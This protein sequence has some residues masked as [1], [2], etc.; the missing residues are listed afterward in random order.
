M[1]KTE[2]IK[3]TE[4]ELKSLVK[5]VVVREFFERSPYPEDREFDSDSEPYEVDSDQGLDESTDMDRYED[6]VFLQ[7]DSADEAIEILDNQGE[8]AAMDYLI[9]WHEPG[10]HMGSS[11]LS[12]GSSDSTYERDGYIMSYNIP[13]NYI[14]LQYE[15]SGMNESK[16]QDKKK[17][18]Q[19]KFDKVMGEFGDGTLKTPSGDVVTDRKQA[20]AIAYSESGLD[21]QTTEVLKEAFRLSRNA[22]ELKQIN[23]QQ[24]E[25]AFNKGYVLYMYL[26]LNGNASLST[27]TNLYFLTKNYFD[28]STPVRI[29]PKNVEPSQV[30]FKAI[31]DAYSRRASESGSDFRIYTLFDVNPYEIN[32]NPDDKITEASDFYGIRNQ[33]AYPK[34]GNIGGPHKQPI[35]DKDFNPKI[36]VEKSKI[37]MFDIEWL[38]KQ[39]ERLFGMNNY[40]DTKRTFD[41]ERNLNSL[42]AIINSFKQQRGSNAPN[43]IEWVVRQFKYGLNN[44]PKEFSIHFGI[45]PDSDK[46]I[47]S[48]LDHGTDSFIGNYEKFKELISKGRPEG[49]LTHESK[50]KL[51]NIVENVVRKVMLEKQDNFKV[52]LG[53]ITSQKGNEWRVKGDSNE[54]F[55]VVRPMDGLLLQMPPEVNEIGANKYGY[56]QVKNTIENLINQKEGGLTESTDLKHYTLKVKHDNGKVNLKT[57]ASSEKEAKE[58]IMKAEGCPESAIISCKEDGKVIKEGRPFQ[59]GKG[60]T[61]FAIDK[62]TGKI[63]NGYDYKGCDPEDLKSD[64]RY[65]FLDDLADYFDFYEPKRSRKDVKIITR[66]KLEVAG[67]DIK[68]SN[69]WLKS[70]D[71]TPENII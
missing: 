43:N 32:N 55:Y 28:G 20:L 40:S 57:T 18:K 69:N 8:D 4:S 68:D 34:G 64:V 42:V 52:L 7:G 59:L 16:N 41:W 24:A 53:V 38:D 54:S 56:E 17:S 5:K 13:L 11:E 66:K 45:D 12:H 27:A 3:I 2:N 6:V 47:L 65:Y 63:I 29:E 62:V 37:G 58:K 9:Q 21:E 61:H 48:F 23:V 39:V 25:E 19:K 71:S 10:H 15:L 44:F 70:S 60:Y 36:G 49:T 1:I 50:Q 51:Y 14:G 33:V 46:S 31:V 22:D 35:K 30:G 67:V 26:P